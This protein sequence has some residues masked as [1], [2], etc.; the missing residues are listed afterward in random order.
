MILFLSFSNSVRKLFTY[1]PS[2]LLTPNDF[3][4]A[5]HQVW[6]L[7]K[8][9]YLVVCF[10]LY[11]NISALVLMGVNEPTDPLWIIYIVW[12]QFLLGNGVLIASIALPISLLAAVFPVSVLLRVCV[13]L[14]MFVFVAYINSNGSI[15]HRFHFIVY[16]SF[17]LIFLPRY[18]VRSTANN[19]RYAL[20]TINV[21][22]LIQ[23]FLLFT[24]TL[25]GLWKLLGFNTVLFTT[26]ALADTVLNRTAQ[27]ASSTLIIWQGIIAKS[28]IIFQVMHVGIVFIQI[29]S[30]LIFFRPHLIKAYGVILIV[31]HF[32]TN[33]LM[34]IS[35]PYHVFAWGL[36][37]ILTPMSQK[38]NFGYMLLSIPLFGDIVRK[39]LQKSIHKNRL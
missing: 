32:G 9:F 21:F 38:T 15:S 36:F 10:I 17:L 1:N 12:E 24:Y 16:I 25:S 39:V 3:V 5:S 26:Q 31:F 30:V 29:I 34:G 6:V 8:V 4:V 37:F 14:I 13:F 28:P 7:V 35:F 20:Q 27:S 11:K 33:F 19:K 22:W 18:K 2:A 23:F